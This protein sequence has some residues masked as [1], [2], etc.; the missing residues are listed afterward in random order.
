M[1]TITLENNKYILDGNEITTEQ[2]FDY[3]FR[4]HNGD[5]SITIYDS[6]EE[7]PVPA[8]EFDIEAHKEEI[9]KLFDEKYREHY[10]AL[11]YS[12]EWEVVQALNSPYSTEAQALIAWYWASFEV[13]KTY[14]A[15]VTS[16]TA[17]S[18]KSIVD[19]LPDFV[20]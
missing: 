6:A 2:I 15:T 9:Y 11:D 3:S 12:G 5:G 14:L 20:I 13:I 18:S 10:A 17:V 4:K 16:D 1:K 7:I 8:Y 19:G